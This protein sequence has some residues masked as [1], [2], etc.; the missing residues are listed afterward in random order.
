[1]CL[2]FVNFTHKNKLALK[3]IQDFSPRFHP[4]MGI[5]RCH[6]QSFHLIHR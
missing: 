3:P 2:Q 5:V 1:M 4:A 6:K